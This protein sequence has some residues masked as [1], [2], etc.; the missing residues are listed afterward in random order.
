MEYWRLNRLGLALPYT[1]SLHC[2][3]VSRVF[4]KDRA[5]KVQAKSKVN[6]ICKLCMTATYMLSL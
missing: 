1:I 4:N 5:V 3:R 6:Y 2:W